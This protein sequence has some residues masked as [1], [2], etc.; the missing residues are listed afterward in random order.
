MGVRYWRGLEKSGRAH[1][2]L[3]ERRW[4]FGLNDIRVTFKLS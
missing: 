2:L 4:R 3:V 1:G